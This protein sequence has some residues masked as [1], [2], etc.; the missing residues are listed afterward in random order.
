MA[1]SLFSPSWYRVA[2]LKPRLRGQLR[3]ERHY[4]RDELWYV[5]QDNATGNTYRFT[6]LFYEVL[7]RMDGKR[8]VQELWDIVAEHQE[9]DFSVTQGE[10]VR[11]LSQLHSSDIL[12]C[13]LP[14][15]TAELFKR[16]RK[17][18]RSKKW[19]N[20]R[21]P[22]SVRFRLFDPETFLAQTA[23][24]IKPFFSFW[25]ALAW[26]AVVAAAVVTAGIHWSELTED[27]MDK[28]LS[29]QN[30]L[31][32]WVVFPAV[33]VL[34]EFGHAYAV[35][36]WGGEVHEMGIM[37]LVFMPVPYVDASASSAF[38][39]K[40][41]RICVSAAGMMVELFIASLA[42][43]VWL[44]VVPGITRSIAFN[45]IFIASVSTILFNAN[46]LLR[47]DGYYILADIIEVSNLAQRSRQYLQHL[48]KQYA[49]KAKNLTPP[50]VA[51]GEHV[52]LMIYCVTAF[53]YRLFLYAGIVLFVAGKFFFI[54]ILLGI[55]TCT[56]MF[57]LPVFKGLQFVLFSPA[58]RIMRARA[59]SIAGGLA[60]AI[61]SLLFLIP[62]PLR[63]VTEGVIW[64]PEES[65]V[66]A[67]MPGFLDRVTAVPDSRVKKGDLLIECSDPSLSAN[68]KMLEAKLREVEAMF[69]IQMSMDPGR[70]RMVWEEITQLN[71]ALARAKEQLDDLKVRSPGDGILVVPSYSDLPGRFIKKG[72]LL[73][74]VV[75]SR[76]PTVRVIAL[77]KDVDLIRK[78]TGSVQVRLAEN[79]GRIIQSHRIREVPG[80]TQR[81]PSN[82]LGSRGGGNVAVDPRDDEGVK[83][84]ENIF[85][86]ELE[87]AEPVHP[88]NIGGRVYV[89]FDHGG[90]PLAFRW[91]RELRR[92]LLRRFNV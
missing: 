10:M 33:K 75:S 66:R 52:W 32:M 80:A 65:L 87:F 49:F 76:N 42:L 14:P 62:F 79:I 6:P 11:L 55:W 5:L 19:L 29:A 69:S 61:L 34:H 68:V 36:V 91:Y 7:G 3:I 39:E 46:P 73:A 16:R 82:V 90:E 60:A 15:D 84:F 83:T 74:Y 18:E 50:Y 35:K 67:G 88:V 12:V 28:V 26:V 1:E 22:M 21:N 64:A 25:G 53:I 56:S 70:A 27:V 38:R 41:R 31:L 9:D 45:V 51:P 63:T 58:I 48:V 86:F 78:R 85:Q 23:R 72:E 54:G 2:S 57:V 89:R 43:F 77:Q 24:Y 92:L 13:N 59:V 4:Y 44:N 30:L 20:L 81:L 47:Y 37:L 8:T 40:W 17:V 71:A